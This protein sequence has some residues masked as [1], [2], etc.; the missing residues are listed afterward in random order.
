VHGGDAPVVTVV[1]QVARV[2]YRHLVRWAL[3]CLH[4]CRGL[5]QLLRVGLETC[6]AGSAWGGG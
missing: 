1:V 4:H 3:A 6:A 2:P 5:E